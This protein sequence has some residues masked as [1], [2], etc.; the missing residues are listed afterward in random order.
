MFSITKLQQ[1]FGIQRFF[2]LY[3]SKEYFGIVYSEDA[4]IAYLV[5]LAGE[6]NPY[7]SPAARQA[8]D[9][10]STMERNIFRRFI[11]FRCQFSLVK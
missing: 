6:K 9:T 5:A 2:L 4:A 8:L 3:I 1:N 7:V 10:A 11:L